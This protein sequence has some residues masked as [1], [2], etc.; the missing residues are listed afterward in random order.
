MQIS[1]RRA[2]A[3]QEARFLEVARI[4]RYFRDERGMTREQ[5][6]GIIDSHINIIDAYRLYTDL[7]GNPLPKDGQTQLAIGGTDGE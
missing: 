7:D 5:L 6:L 3:R 4:V 2:F 1:G